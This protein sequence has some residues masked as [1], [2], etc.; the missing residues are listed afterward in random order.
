M[1]LTARNPL[2]SSKTRQLAIPCCIC[3]VGQISTLLHPKVPLQTSSV[4]SDGKHGSLKPG[5]IFLSTVALGSVSASNLPSLRWVSPIAFS[6]PHSKFHP[7]QYLIPLPIPNLYIL[8]ASYLPLLS[9][10]F[11]QRSDASRFLKQAT[12]SCASCNISRKST[13]TGYPTT[14]PS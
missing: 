5:T 9:Y 10:E 4:P 11:N 1:V 13:A 2:A 14:G 8:Y 3:T 12:L 6:V 7:D